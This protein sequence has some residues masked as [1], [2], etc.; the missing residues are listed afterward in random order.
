MIADQIDAGETVQ[1]TAAD[2]DLATAESDDFVD[3]NKM[4][5]LSF[6]RRCEVNDLGDP[7]ALAS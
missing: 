6:G 3:V 7:D 2:Y 1:D 4:V 5:E